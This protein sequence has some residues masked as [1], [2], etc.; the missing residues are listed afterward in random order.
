M[1]RHRQCIERNSGKVPSCPGFT[2]GSHCF[3]SNI[4]KLLFEKI[5]IFLSKRNL[6]AFPKSCRNVDFATACVGGLISTIVNTQMHMMTITISPSTIFVF[7]Y[8][9]AN[10]APAASGDPA[11]KYTIGITNREEVKEPRFAKTCRVVDILVRSAGFEDNA[12][13]IGVNGIFTNVYPK[14]N[15]I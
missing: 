9:D 12:V 10:S 8:P 7:L 6:N 13:T 15:T 1:G 3:A 14:E 4:K 2:V 5:F 11:K